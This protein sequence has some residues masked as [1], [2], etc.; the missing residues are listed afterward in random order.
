M[1]KIY[2]DI[3]HCDDGLIGGIIVLISSKEMSV[4]EYKTMSKRTMPLH[5][6]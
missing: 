1:I 6:M 3:D 4:I 2:H 5:C